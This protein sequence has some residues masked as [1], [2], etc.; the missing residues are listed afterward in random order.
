MPRLARPTHRA[1][2]APEPYPRALSLDPGRL[3]VV[4]AI[5][6]HSATGGAARADQARCQSLGY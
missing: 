5:P 4:G 2:A 1:P 3:A 6:A